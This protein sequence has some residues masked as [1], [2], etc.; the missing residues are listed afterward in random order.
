MGVS[1]QS[2]RP[3]ETVVIMFD[4]LF[5]KCQ[6]FGCAWSGSARVSPESDLFRRNPSWIKINFFLSDVSLEEQ[7]LFK[8]STYSSYQ[9]I[10]PSIYPVGAV[11]FWVAQA[12]GGS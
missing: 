1:G 3:D 6:T 10:H 7:V 11:G 9:I 12:C 5:R 2:L 4:C 8:I